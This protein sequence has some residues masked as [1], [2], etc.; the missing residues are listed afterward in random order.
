M[1][2]RFVFLFAG[3]FSVLVFFEWYHYL[4]GFDYSMWTSSNWFTL[5]FVLVA[6]AF[7]IG[8]ITMAVD[9]ALPAIGGRAPTKTAKHR[10][11]SRQDYRA[12]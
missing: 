7:A 12:R 4:R 6:E 11:R 2:P 1:T 10:R 8:I 5:L 9:R 3:L